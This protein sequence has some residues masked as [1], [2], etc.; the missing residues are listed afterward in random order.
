MIITQKQKRLMT[1]GGVL[2]ILALLI[3][4][5][6][7]ALRLQQIGIEPVAP[8]V[9]KSQPKAQGAIPTPGADSACRKTFQIAQGPTL[10]PTVTPTGGAS[11]TATP[12]GERGGLVCTNISITGGTTRKTGEQINLTCSGTPSSDVTQCRFRFGDGSAEALEDD[13]NILHSYSSVGT[14]PVS[15]EVKD[16]SGSWKSSGACGGQ[17]EITAVTGSGT[18]SLT[19]TKKL[20]GNPTAGTTS[21]PTKVPTVAQE[22]LP[23]AGGLGPTLGAITAGLGA[24]IMG[25]L[26][27]L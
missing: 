23:K 7:T 12:T 19:P 14:Y 21:G 16:R 20:T 22:S 26:L 8:S 4:A 5:V 13:C 25:I 2:L 9:P 24:V 10:T 3:I 1:I 6:I 27:I 11:P 15:C 17:I 18:P